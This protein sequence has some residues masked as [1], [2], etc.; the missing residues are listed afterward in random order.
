MKQFPIL[1][2][3]LCIAISLHAQEG[4]FTDSRDG[5]EYKTVQIGVQVW[6]AE[7]LNYLTDN[8]WCYGNDPTNCITYGRLY[9][10]ETA[11]NVCPEGWHL[12]TDAE[13][14]GLTYNLG[15]EEVA[16]DNLKEAGL[17]H[18]ESSNEGA[19][20]SICFTGLPGGSRFSPGYFDFLGHYGYWWK[21]YGVRCLQ[22]L[23]PHPGLQYR[24]CVQ[25]Q[26]R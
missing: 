3:L 12:P 8:S 4:T 26:Q 2:A 17:A 15:G 24:L 23:V 7:N 5:Q 21:C 20:N 10:W 18:W 16:G 11:L 22:C 13:W 9:D 1:A 25:V 14:K 19:T 6:M